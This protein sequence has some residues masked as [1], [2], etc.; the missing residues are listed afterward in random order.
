VLIQFLGVLG[1]LTS[2]IPYRLVR[3][4]EGP[5]GHLDHPSVFGRIS[6]LRV[7]KFVVVSKLMK[8]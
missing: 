7:C 6:E 5:D 4:Y 8:Y 3:K 1:S 2:P